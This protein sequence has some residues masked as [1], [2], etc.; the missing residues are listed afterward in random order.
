MKIR[1]I[2]NKTKGI[3]SN[4]RYWIKAIYILLVPLFLLSLSCVLSIGI[5]SL[6]DI[7]DEATRVQIAQLISGVLV[8][9]GSGLFLGLLFSHNPRKLLALKE[10][11]SM[12]I[13]LSCFAA[14]A[15]IPL[16]N[17][18]SSLNEH[19]ITYLNKQVIPG[20]LNSIIEMEAT[21]DNVIRLL[22]GDMHLGT[23]LINLLVMAV[24]PA[25]GEELFFRGMLLGTINRSI[26]NHHICIWITAVA[27]SLVH[28]QLGKFLPILLMGGMFGYLRIW[29]KSLWLP[30]AAHMVN[31]G[32][33]VIYYFFFKGETYGIDPENIGTSGTPWI[34]LVFS[35]LLIALLTDI[36][37]LAKSGPTRTAL[38]M[39]EENTAEN[40]K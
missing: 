25:I 19:F 26:R 40:K 32:V 15:A 34:L 8:F 14:L 31:N 37:R 35:V 28:F 30:I 33:I 20:A 38:L 2:L 16:I 11:N 39:E 23:M 13:L 3:F 4:D 27:F 6:F 7:T 5:L 10:G 1:T 21:N 36:R 9:I 18:I 17:Y 29:S 24:L 22:L 12:A